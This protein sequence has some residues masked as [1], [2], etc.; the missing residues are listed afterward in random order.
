LP[1]SLDSVDTPKNNLFDPLFCFFHTFLPPSPGPRPPTARQ[2]GCFLAVFSNV[3]SRSLLTLFI[4]SI[5][6]VYG[7]FLH[8]NDPASR[9]RV[10][11]PRFVKKHPAP[12]VPPLFVS[13]VSPQVFLLGF[14]TVAF[15]DAFN[16]AFQ[17]PIVRGTSPWFPKTF[18]FR[19]FPWVFP[20]W[21]TLSSILFPLMC[22]K[23]GRVE[24]VLMSTPLGQFG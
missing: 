3:C 11:E 20:S 13:L 8:P 19:F 17:P 22:D 23:P 2:Q 14:F 4:H 18:S 24:R 6:C 21:Y 7:F 10:L 16:C 1:I 15:Q 5:L 12:R 9:M